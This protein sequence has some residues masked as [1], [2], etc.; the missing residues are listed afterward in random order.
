[1][2][3]GIVAPES[4]ICGEENYTSPPDLRILHFNDVYHVEP[5]E[6]D[7]VGGVTRFQSMCNFYR[8]A[9]DF[10]GQPDLISFFSGDGFNPSL[11]S[12]VT[13][14]SH[15]VPILNGIPTAAACVGNHDLDLGVPQFEY[16]SSQCNF[17]W[18]L[19]NV[20]D[21]AL[22]D[23][24]PL[25]HALKTVMMTS[26]NGIKIGIIGLV[27]QE[28]LEA[29]NAL[30]PDLIYRESVDVALELVPKLRAQG[31][32]IIIALAHQREYH[33][34]R[35]AQN[36]P[37]GLIDIILGGHDHHYRYTKIK[38]THVLCSGSDF[39][40]ISYIEMRKSTSKSQNWDFTIKRRDI[41]KSIPEDPATVEVLDRLFSSLLTKLQKPIGYTAVPLD[42]R[43]STVRTRESNMGNFVSD[44][45]RYYYD[46]DCGIMCGGTIRGDVIYAPGILRLKDI[47]DCFPFEDPTVLVKVKGGALLK[48]LENGVCHYPALD[49]RFPQVSNIDFVFDPSKPPHHRII[50]VKV[51][52]SNLDLDREY[53]VATRDYMA[54]GGDGYT[55]LSLPAHG[56]TA[57]P[58]VKEENGILISM[59]LRQ[60]FMSSMTLGRWKN[61]NA[62][63]GK[64][65]G[66]VH[67]KLQ[68]NGTAVEM[69]DTKGAFVASVARAVECTA[70]DVPGVVGRVLRNET[71]YETRPDTKQ[72]ARP[73]KHGQLGGREDEHMRLSDSEDD[74]RSLR[75]PAMAVERSRQEK[76]LM[77]ARKAM[78]K[79]WRLAGLDEKSQ[80]SMGYESREEL[81]VGWTRGICPRVEGR[82]RLVS[83][84]D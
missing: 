74:G 58:L 46:G 41:T 5:S 37:A 59:L 61:W 66:N 26:S 34:N 20:I 7:P 65:W 45:M 44:L 67:T 4:L 6:S 79:W 8:H 24:V 70:Q 83:A 17:P 13:K 43:T 32:E 60:H 81:G 21:P 19:A 73:R 48:A 15:M 33:D 23:D 40:Q 14:G 53:S 63:L 25:G 62:A 28:W 11:E 75:V 54:R 55:S 29:V 49:G 10:E 9:R 18:L 57:V 68:R 30:P 82:I 2:G 42:A 78:R 76:E 38:G 64:H 72:E 69:A 12:S 1:M 47:M 27:E 3:A 84:T 35:L 31:A 71:I 50:S 52:G 22:G 16:L 80:H 39:K 36:T 56:G 77:I 51:G